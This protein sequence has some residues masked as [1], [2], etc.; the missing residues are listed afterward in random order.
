MSFS[1]PIR[2]FVPAGGN[3]L[4]NS[5]FQWY[6]GKKH[7]WHDVPIV[8]EDPGDEIVECPSETGHGVPHRVCFLCLGEGQ[9]KRGEIEARMKRLEEMAK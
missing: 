8:Y 2:I 1:I 6:S 9:A 5:R 3:L 4:E 7:G